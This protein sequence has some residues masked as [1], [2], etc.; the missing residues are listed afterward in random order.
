LEPSRTNLAFS[1]ET[2]GGSGVG[3]VYMN[4]KIDVTYTPNYGISPEGVKNSTRVQFND[5]TAFSYRAVSLS[6]D[7]TGSLYVKGTAGEDIRFG[8][9][10]NVA[11]DGTIH[12]FDGTWQRVTHTSSTGTQFYLSNYTGTGNQA[13]DFEIYGLQ[14]E[15]GSYATS[16]IPTYGAAATRSK[17]G[18]AFELSVLD[19]FSL[20][21]SE[22]GT[23]FLETKFTKSSS[24]TKV[25]IFSQGGSGTNTYSGT[26]FLVRDTVGNNNFVVQSL[27]SVVD[28]YIKMIIR[29]DGTTFNVFING[30]KS[31]TT[32]TITN[33]LKWFDHLSTYRNSQMVKQMLEFPE[34][35]SDA[36]CITLTTL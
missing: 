16:Y 33:P 32:N 26:T 24:E 4:S 18:D 1:S 35:L 30:V 17:E 2:F 25:D 8:F 27:D 12:T 14:H 21:T 6:E 13:S 19:F 23:F 22:S 29:K 3:S 10:I 7:N 28:D 9:G 20:G 11:T 15:I 34:A 5:S 31:S 36:E